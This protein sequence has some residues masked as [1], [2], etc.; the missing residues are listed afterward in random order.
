MHSK[1]YPHLKV[2]LDGDVGGAVG[3][4]EPHALVLDERRRR[5]DVLLLHDDHGSSLLG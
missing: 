4:Q 1:R 3:D 2:G 5:S